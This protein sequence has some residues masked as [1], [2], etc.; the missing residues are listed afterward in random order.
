MDKMSHP[1]FYYAEDKSSLFV[2][3]CF[4]PC[5]HPHPHFGLSYEPRTPR[6]APATFPTILAQPYLDAWPSLSRV[7]K[8]ED[9]KIPKIMPVQAI[10]LG[11]AM[12]SSLVSRAG[13]AR[14]YSSDCPLTAAWRLVD[15]GV[16]STIL[17]YYQTSA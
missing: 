14:F 11:E 7:A 3:F 6:R 16:F 17:Y 13:S 9:T 2:N 10:L 4:F 5:H 8:A 15:I 1:W 12:L